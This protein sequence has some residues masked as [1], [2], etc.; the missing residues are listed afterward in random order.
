[1]KAINDILLDVGQ[2]TCLLGGKSSG[3]S[4]V[5]KRLLDDCN[6]PIIVMNMRLHSGNYL[7]GLKSALGSKSNIRNL[8]FC[9][10]EEDLSDSEREAETI[11]LMRKFFTSCAAC[12]TMRSLFGVIE[13]FY[14]NCVTLIL[15]EADAAFTVTEDTTAAE[16]REMKELLG[17]LKVLTKEFGMVQ[18]SNK[19]SLL[20]TLSTLFFC[21][22]IF[23]FTYIIYYSKVQRT[24]TVSK[25]STVF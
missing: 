9:R 5:I 11:I 24:L 8:L 17:L 20:F 12:V 14:K 2:L 10:F 25:C 13:D 1:M 7:E 4:L 23:C 15:D 18:Y 6:H 22:F 16:L 21:V 19:H 3:K